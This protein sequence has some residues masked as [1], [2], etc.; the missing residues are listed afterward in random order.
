M[1][2]WRKLQHDRSLNRFRHLIRSEHYT[3]PKEADVALRVYRAQHEEHD[4]Q[5]AALLLNLVNNSPIDM[6][7]NFVDHHYAKLMAEQALET[8]NIHVL[9]ELLERVNETLLLELNSETEALR[10]ELHTFEALRSRP[11]WVALTSAVDTMLSDQALGDILRFGGCLKSD[12]TDALRV[13]TSQGLEYASQLAEVKAKLLR[14]QSCVS[15][16]E[17]LTSEGRG[18]LLDQLRVNCK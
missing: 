18:E 14:I 13:L 11:H 9:C 6:T 12:F 16:K 8:T 17:G 4:K 1:A 2:K 10:H 3:H 7:S 5:R 15:F